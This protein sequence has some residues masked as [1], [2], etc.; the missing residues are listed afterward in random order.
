MKITRTVNATIG[1]IKDRATITLH[2]E[3]RLQ[4]IDREYYKK[5]VEVSGPSVHKP[6]KVLASFVKAYRHQ[7]ERLKIQEQLNAPF[8]QDSVVMANAK[9][10]L[11]GII[12]TIKKA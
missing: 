12:N 10:L 8:K 7:V 3:K 6:K 11:K 9:T 1:A 2:S 5:L 4:G